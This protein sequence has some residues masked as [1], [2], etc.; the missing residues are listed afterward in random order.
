MRWGVYKWGL[1]KKGGGRAR[2]V[3]KFKGRDLTRKGGGGAGR[4]PNAH[5][6]VVAF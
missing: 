5:Y 3:C 6:V 2:T 1:P 4:Y